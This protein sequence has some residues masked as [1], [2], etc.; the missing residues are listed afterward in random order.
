MDWNHPTQRVFEMD[1][2]VVLQVHWTCPMCHRTGAPDG[3]QCLVSAE[4]QSLAQ[5]RPVYTGPGHQ[6]GTMAKWLWSGTVKSNVFGG[7]PDWCT[8]PFAQRSC[9]Y[10]VVTSVQY[11]LDLTTRQAVLLIAS[12]GLAI[13]A[14]PDVFG[15]KAR[16]APDRSDVPDFC[17]WKGNGQFLDLVLY[18]PLHIMHFNS[19]RIL[20]IQIH[21]L[22]SKSELWPIGVIW[23]LL[24][25]IKDS[26]CAYIHSSRQAW[27]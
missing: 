19:F 13:G 25:K 17:G 4:T 23:I 16:T 24:V 6:T 12:L 10:N 5:W 9:Q 3:Q 22:V 8:A 18:I 14:S 1:E 26:I 21:P 27:W 11:S 20:K 7:A 2:L 15:A